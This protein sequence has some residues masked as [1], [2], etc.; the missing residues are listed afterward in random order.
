MLEATRLSRG[1]LEEPNM[2]SL[3]QFIYVCGVLHPHMRLESAIY[4]LLE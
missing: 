4:V 3:F 2:S 1:L